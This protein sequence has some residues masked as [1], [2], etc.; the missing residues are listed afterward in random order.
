VKPKTRPTA[1]GW[2]GLALS[3]LAVGLLP[4]T[5]WL[6]DLSVSKAAGHHVSGIGSL[7][8]SSFVATLAAFAAATIIDTLAGRRG[9]GNRVVGFVGGL[10]MLSPVVVLIVSL[11]VSAARFGQ[12]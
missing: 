6:F 12:P 11:I 9:R 4:V 8:T 2:I 3:V 5:A 1:I 7:W 10:I